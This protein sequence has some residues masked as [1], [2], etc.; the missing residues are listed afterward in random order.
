MKPATP[1]AATAFA[2]MPTAAL[3]V[4][5]AGLA[6]VTRAET[7]LA[8][9]DGFQLEWRVVTFEVGRGMPEEPVP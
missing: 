1:K 6:E 4:A 3:V 7:E 2:L 5:T 8:V 9:K